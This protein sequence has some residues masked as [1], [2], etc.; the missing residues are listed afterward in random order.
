MNAIQH[1]YDD[2]AKVKFTLQAEQAKAEM[3]S[4][5]FIERRNEYKN[6]LSALLT[7]INNVLYI[8]GHSKQ[9]IPLL[10]RVEKIRNELSM[11]VS[12]EEFRKLDI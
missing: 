6:M 3:S 1:I 11:C 10:E 5:N 8:E 9:L 12:T 4:N 7:S 2:Y